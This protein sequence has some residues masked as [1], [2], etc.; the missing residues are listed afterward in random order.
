[1]RSTEIDTFPPLR[2]CAPFPHHQRHNSA[3]APMSCSGRPC[4]SCRCF[5]H[6]VTASCRR[7]FGHFWPEVGALAH[8]RGSAPAARRRRARPAV[9]PRTRVAKVLGI[10][11]VQVPSRRNG[12]TGPPLC[13]QS[14]TAHGR[15]DVA[16]QPS[17]VMCRSPCQSACAPAFR[18]RLQAVSLCR[19]RGHR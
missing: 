17:V 2:A 19:C 18:T 14:R 16:A 4:A 3:R 7:H 6:A 11:A 5:V 1:M 12:S 15:L 13:N 8:G 9:R 10:G